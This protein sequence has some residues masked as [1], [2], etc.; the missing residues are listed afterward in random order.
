MTNFALLTARGFFGLVPPFCSLFHFLQPE[1]YPPTPK[2]YTLRVLLCSVDSY[3]CLHLRACLSATPSPHRL[4]RAEGRDFASILW[5]LCVLRLRLM[6]FA[7]TALRLV[8][9]ESLTVAQT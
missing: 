2:K 1:V 5:Q 9:S 7:A 3:P 4:V 8:S 6:P